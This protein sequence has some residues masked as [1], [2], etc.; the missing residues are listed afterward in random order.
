MLEGRMEESGK[1]QAMFSK[2]PGAMRKRVAFGAVATFM[3]LL[4]ALGT[5][6]V[7]SAPAAAHGMGDPSEPLKR[8]MAAYPEYFGLHSDP[9][10]PPR[11]RRCRDPQGISADNWNCRVR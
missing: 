1:D 3:L 11:D 5:Y 9:D 8:T 7:S 2:A 10:L 6:F 4:P